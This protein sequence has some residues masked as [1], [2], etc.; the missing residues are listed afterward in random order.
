MTLTEQVQDQSTRQR[1]SVELVWAW[2]EARG[3]ILMQSLLRLC[4]TQTGSR[5][6]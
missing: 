2:T 3:L 4:R 1:E 6:H 5:L